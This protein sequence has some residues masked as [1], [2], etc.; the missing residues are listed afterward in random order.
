MIENPATQPPC[1]ETLV[2]YGRVSTDEQNMSLQTDAADKARIHPELRYFDIESGRKLKRD[3]LRNALRCCSKG[4]TLVVWKLD[5][6]GRNTAELIMTIKKLHEKGVKFRSLTQSEISTENM[7]TA[8][9]QLIFHIFSELAEFESAQLAERTKAGMR[10]AKARGV[11]F[12]RRSFFDMPEYMAPGG[13]VEQF[14]KCRSDGGRV[15]ECL[16]K[17]DIPRPTYLKFK[18]VFN[19]QPVDDIDADES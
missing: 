19:A 15:K 1:D 14:Q 9:G 16:E 10:S 8:T 17:L 2:F 3:G 13:K 11:Q 18:D 5:R 12:G 4:S 7:E 6:L